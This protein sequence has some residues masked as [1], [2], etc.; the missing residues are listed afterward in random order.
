MRV[1]ING[2]IGEIDTMPGCSQIGISHAVFRPVIKR[3]KGQGGLAHKGRLT[4]MEDL[5]YDYALCTVDMSNEA[6]L[7]IL[8]KYGWHQIDEFISSKTGHTVGLFGRPLVS[9]TLPHT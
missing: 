7:H 2:T 9:H 6:Q 5:G 3:G 8:K 4:H 1:V